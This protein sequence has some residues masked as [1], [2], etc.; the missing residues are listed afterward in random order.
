[1]KKISKSNIVLFCL[2]VFIVLLLI[3]GVVVWCAQDHSAVVFI[4]GVRWQGRSYSYTAGKY[5]EGETIAWGQDGWEVNEVEQDPSHTFIVVRSFL[6]QHL[7][8]ADDYTIPTSGKVTMAAWNNWD[9]IYDEEFLNV[10]SEIVESRESSFIYETGRIGITALSENQRMKALAL[11]Y[12]GCPV[13]T[14]HQ[15]YMGKLNGKWVLAVR[16]PGNEDDLTNRT[17]KYDCYAIPDKY[18]DVLAKY[19]FE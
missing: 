9:F 19:F 15:G 8:V 13:A 11:A 18:A 17:D 6:D 4:E 10:V 2:A 5:T 1:M 16:I 14:E 7:C 3:T 12:E